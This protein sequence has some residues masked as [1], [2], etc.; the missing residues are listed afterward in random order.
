MK[1]NEEVIRLQDEAAGN[2]HHPI[3]DGLQTYFAER[4]RK[5]EEIKR[6][7]NHLS[8]LGDLIFGSTDYLV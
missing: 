8:I 7:K 5:L 1:V 6:Q 3:N 2:P 4:K